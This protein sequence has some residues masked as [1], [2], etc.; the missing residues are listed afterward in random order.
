MD[1]FFIENGVHRAV[2]ARE[3]RLRAIPAMLYSPGQKPRLVFV[4]LDQLYSPRVS[5]SRSDPRH[6]YPALE[7]AMGATVGRSRIP[8]IDVQPRG[9]PGQ[10]ASIPLALVTIDV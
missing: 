9:E 3:N 10:P 8:P 7:R 1:E 2:A 4:L 5:I 6:N